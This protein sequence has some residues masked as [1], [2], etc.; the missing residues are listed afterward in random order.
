MSSC[1]RPE[2][3]R[4]KF[5]QRLLLSPIILDPLWAYRFAIRRL[6]RVQKAVNQSASGIQM[7]RRAAALIHDLIYND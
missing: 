2:F 1:L 4:A 5:F 7:T 3:L 6:L